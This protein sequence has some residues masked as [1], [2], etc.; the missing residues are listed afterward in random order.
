VFVLV[1]RLTGKIISKV[2]YDFISLSSWT[3]NSTQ[4]SLD[5]RSVQWVLF[6]LAELL[7][8]FGS[9]AGQ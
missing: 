6:A 7:V 4:L 9:D 5:I 1:K 8:G 2:T 3:L